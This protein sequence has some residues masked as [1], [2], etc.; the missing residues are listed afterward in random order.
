MTELTQTAW[1]ILTGIVAFGMVQ[2]LRALAL[3][4]RNE[5]GV[6]DLRVRVSDL[7]AARLRDQMTRHGIGGGNEGG[8]FE[9]M[10]VAEAS[11]NS[12]VIDEQAQAA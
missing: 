5:V 1:L 2:L 6:H 4:V 7:R 12:G 8:D 11:D 9:I 10:E 3:R